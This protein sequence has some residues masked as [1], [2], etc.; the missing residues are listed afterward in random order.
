MAPAIV[1]AGGRRGKDGP[2]RG[3]PIRDAPTLKTKTAAGGSLKSERGMGYNVSATVETIY[4]IGR[5]SAVADTIAPRG[6]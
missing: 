2:G 6:A 1:G 5:S 4:A 3:A